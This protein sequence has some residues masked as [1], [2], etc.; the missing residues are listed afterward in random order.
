MPVAEPAPS[1]PIS[2][3]E[4]FLEAF[5]NKDAVAIIAGAI[6]KTDTTMHTDALKAPIVNQIVL[7]Y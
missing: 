7:H 4:K 2:V 5:G 3:H 6:S 1:A